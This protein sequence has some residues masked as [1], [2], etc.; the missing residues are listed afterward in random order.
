MDV[1]LGYRWDPPRSG[2]CFVEGENADGATVDDDNFRITAPDPQ[3][4]TTS[5]APGQ[6]L[7]AIP[8]TRE[9]AAEGG[10]QQTSTGVAWTDPAE[11]AVLRDALAPVAPPAP[12]MPRAP[13]IM[14]HFGI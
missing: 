6:V 2:W 4:P 10:Y 11:A 9:G 13:V 5:S 3:G 7:S 14:P 12:V 8:G 1:V